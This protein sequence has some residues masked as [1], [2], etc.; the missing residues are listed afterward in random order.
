MKNNRFNR[1]KWFAVSMATTGFCTAQVATADDLFSS[2]RSTGNAVFGVEAPADPAAATAAS[3][4]AAAAQ[5]PISDAQIQALMAKAKADMEKNSSLYRLKS[6]LDGNKSSAAPAARTMNATMMPAA[7]PGYANAPQPAAMTTG[8]NSDGSTAYAPLSAPTLDDASVNE[9]AF[10][11]MVRSMLPLTPEQIQTLRYLFDRTKRAAASTPGAPPKPISTSVYVNLSPGATPPV[12][13]MAQ[14][15]ISTLVFLD[16]TGQPWPIK[17]TDL[18][19]PKNFNVVV[20]GSSIMVQA[21]SE[22]KNANLAVS[23]KGLDTPVM[24]TLMPGQAV[25]DYRADLHI[26]QLGPNAQITG[27]TL[28]STESADL[29]NV[30]NGIPPQGASTL[31]VAGADA[32][33]WQAHGRY[34]LRT[35]LTL[36]SPGW[37]STMTSADGMHAYELPSTPVM[38]AADHGHVIKLSVI[39]V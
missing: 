25:V 20:D 32:S 21:S 9:Q 30:L 34:F 10:S 36:M 16:G 27:N 19:D 38:L 31:Q 29:L 8:M 22:Y 6:F 12:I 24:L 15:F 1:L 26:P 13:R 4:P 39:E 11:N 3:A 2:M 7:A 18:G 37:I 23:L 14:G 5:P 35:R 17:A 33:L 28:P